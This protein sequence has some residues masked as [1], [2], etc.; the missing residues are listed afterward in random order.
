MDELQRKYRI[1]GLI[2]YEYH[3]MGIESHLVLGFPSYCHLKTKTSLIT[4]YQHSEQSLIEI[5]EGLKK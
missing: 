4:N 5:L 3:K 1:M 2:A